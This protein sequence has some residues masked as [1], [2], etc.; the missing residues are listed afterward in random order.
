M[1]STR[2]FGEKLTFSM[3]SHPEFTTPSNVKV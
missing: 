3:L 2:A 1:N